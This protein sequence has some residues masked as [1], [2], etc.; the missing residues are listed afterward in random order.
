MTSNKYAVEIDDLDAD[1][2][3]LSDEELLATRGGWYI[4]YDWCSCVAGGDVDLDNPVFY[5]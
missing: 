1:G 3:E 2:P 4:Q 5:F